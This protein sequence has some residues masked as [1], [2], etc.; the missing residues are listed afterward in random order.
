MVLQGAAV[1]AELIY[2]LLIVS[3]ATTP[4]PSLPVFSLLNQEDVWTASDERRAN[5]LIR[6]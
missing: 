4:N 6:R 1:S 5:V 2:S 3:Q